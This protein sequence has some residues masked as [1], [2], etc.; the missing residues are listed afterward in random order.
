MNF[1]YCGEY[2]DLA[3]ATEKPPRWAKCPRAV[4][5]HRVAFL[6]FFAFLAS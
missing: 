4:H 6:A 5:V 2:L 3:N 1:K